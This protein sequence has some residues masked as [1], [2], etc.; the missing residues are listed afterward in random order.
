MS[1]YITLPSNSSADYFPDNTNSHYFTHLEE[2]LRFEE[3]EWE[4]ALADLSYQNTWNNITE[5]RLT[6]GDILD[7]GEDDKLEITIR[8]EMNLNKGRVDSI[9]ELIFLI[10]RALTC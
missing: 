3:G 1:L 4:V 2:R 5:G 7:V 6:V 9:P 10:Q 8:H